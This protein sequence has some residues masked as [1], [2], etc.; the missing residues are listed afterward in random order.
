MGRPPP[1]SGRWWRRIWP[2]VR[3]AAIAR[4]PKRPRARQSRT[5]LSALRPRQLRRDVSQPRR[6]ERIGLAGSN[7]P[8]SS[9]AVYS[10]AA[11]LMV[12]GVLLYGLTRLSPT[13]LAAQLT[14]D[15]MK[16]FAVD[17]PDTPV[18]AGA[19]SWDSR[20]L[21]WP[22]HLPRA[23]VAGL[24]L[25]GIRQCFCAQGAP[26]RTR[27]IASTAGPCLLCILPM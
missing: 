4:R 18:E 24:Q 8:F 2:P 5:A 12:G 19:R 10:A 26:R 13:V 23:S 7:P 20:A 21:R 11:V 22:V 16:C 25:V 3:P 1:P 17:R 9:N 14:L 27:C 6:S 15:H